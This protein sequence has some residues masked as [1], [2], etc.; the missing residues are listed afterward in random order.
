MKIKFI[1]DILAEIYLRSMEVPVKLLTRYNVNP[2]TFTTIGLVISMIAAICLCYGQFLIAGF[3]IFIGGTF[4]ILDGK[5]AR[6][7][8]RGSKFGALFDSTLDRYSEMFLFFGLGF[9]FLRNEMFLSLLGAFIALGGSMMVSYVRARSEGLG[10][11]CK[12]GIM[13][14]QERI[15]YL[16]LGSILSGIPYFNYYPIKL[17]VWLIAVL[18]NFTSIQRV[19]YIWHQ[20]KEEEVN[21]EEISSNEQGIIQNKI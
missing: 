10:F 18:A 13:Q 7:T 6:A 4:D 2:N 20:A 11:Q 17:V 19:W 3:L 16:G 14:R 9:F 1:P 12:V 15:V 5:I 21:S 8:G